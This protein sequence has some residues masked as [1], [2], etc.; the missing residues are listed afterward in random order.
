[1][2]YAILYVVGIW[3]EHQILYLIRKPINRFLMRWVWERLTSVSKLNPTCLRY[4]F[5]NFAKKKKKKKKNS[6]NSNNNN[7]NNKIASRKERHREKYCQTKKR[8]KKHVY[9]SS[10]IHRTFIPFA[11][12]RNILPL[13]KMPFCYILSNFK[14]IVVTTLCLFNPNLP[15]PFWGCSVSIWSQSHFWR[16][17]KLCI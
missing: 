15:G 17:G 8:H 6:N 3:F 16:L 2:S 11:N 13:L 5:Y 10:H 9:H 1:M 7:N 14:D 12:A 4:M